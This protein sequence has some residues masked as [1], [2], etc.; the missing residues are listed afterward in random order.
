MSRSKEGI[1]QCS[2]LG[3]AAGD[4][5]KHLIIDNPCS[6]DLGP[7]LYNTCLRLPNLRSIS[8]L[9][10]AVD[11]SLGLVEPLD[12]E[13][14]SDIVEVI[15]GKRGREAIL[16]IAP[17]ITEWDLELTAGAA[18]L[19]LSGNYDGNES[20]T[21]ASRETLG[22]HIL[23]TDKSKF[24]SLLCKLPNLHTLSIPQTRED[25]EGRDAE[26]V[27]D[28]ILS[29]SFPFATSLRNLSLDLERDDDRTTPNE[30]RFAAMF[31]NLQ[32]LKIRFRS[33]NLTEIDQEFY[34]LPKLTS[35]DI[36]DCPF[37]FMHTLVHVLSLP[38]ISSI[39][40]KNIDVPIQPPTEDQESEELRR[41][42]RELESYPSSLRSLR[43]QFPW[44]LPSR[45]LDHLVPLSS[46]IDVVIAPKPEQSRS[47]RYGWRGRSDSSDSDRVLELG[48]LGGGVDSAGVKHQHLFRRRSGGDNAFKSTKELVDWA[49]ERV[50][51][52]GT[53][54]DVGLQEMSRMLEPIRDLKEWIE[55]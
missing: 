11:E 50:Y 34:L 19:L 44:D 47:S 48:S 16:R 53:V 6:D 49:Q 43:L 39:R 52:C 9:T 17:Q 27:H 25:F 2:I 41:L 15:N 12:L 5:I 20:L 35:L 29:L 28:S 32:T 22:A 33:D 51:S 37:L 8:E 40:I 10:E 46:E 26:V 31:P 45:V 55:D 24:P 13:V 4:C 30:V 38:S 7:F 21:L 1:F 3:S 42:V 14:S 23:E 36:F 18:E 54:D